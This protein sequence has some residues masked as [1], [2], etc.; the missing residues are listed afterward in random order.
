MA[1]A[2][3]NGVAVFTGRGGHNVPATVLIVVVVEVVVKVGRM[4][5][6]KRP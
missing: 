3:S 4:E 6:G 2:P 1:T 5:K